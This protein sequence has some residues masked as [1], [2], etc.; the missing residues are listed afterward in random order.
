LG[1]DNLFDARQRVTDS[2]GEVPLSYQAFLLDPAGRFIEF[3][4]RKI[5]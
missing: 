3:E 4:I 2:N 5:F 1:V